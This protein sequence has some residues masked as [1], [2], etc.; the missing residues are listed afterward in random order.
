MSTGDSAGGG[1][2]FTAT[3]LP[4]EL[5]LNLTM[6]TTIELYQEAIALLE[7]YIEEESDEDKQD[8]A[9][10]LVGDCILVV[11]ELDFHELGEGKSPLAVLEANLQAVIDRASPDA[12]SGA[13][14]AGMK[15]LVT[16]ITGALQEMAP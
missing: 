11:Q 3:R 14:I 9:T 15:R 1:L 8:G 16:G 10:Q 6:T 2:F 12:A 7:S 5:F 4:N 13:A